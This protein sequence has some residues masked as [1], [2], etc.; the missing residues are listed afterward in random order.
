M[1]PVY[2]TL[3][4]SLPYLSAWSASN[5]GNSSRNCEDMYEVCTAWIGGSFGINSAVD[6]LLAL[7]ECSF[8][9]VSPQLY[10]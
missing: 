5:L 1:S 7:P 9:L 4:V 2:T 10:V 8:S 3:S 6:D